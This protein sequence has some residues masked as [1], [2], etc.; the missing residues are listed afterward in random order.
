M[1]TRKTILVVEDEPMSRKMLQ[2]VLGHSYEVLVSSNAAE[3][4]R[5]LTTHPHIKCI[6]SDL[7]M[8]QTDG[9]TLI[10][11]IRARWAWAHIPIIVL[12][13]HQ[14]SQTR[15]ECLE[16]GAD[17][18][19]VKPFNPKELEAK[20]AAVLR[21]QLGMFTPHWTG[22][23][24][25]T[26]ASPSSRLPIP[27]WKR[28]FDILVASV[29]LTL[30]SPLLAVIAVLIKLDSRGT[31]FYTSKRVGAGY[32]VFD[33]YKFRTMCTQADQ[34][35]ANMEDLNMYQSPIAKAHTPTSLCQQCEVHGACQNRLLKENGW[36]CEQEFLQQCHQKAAFKKFQN[37][38]RITKLGRFLR[39][40]SLDE[41]PQLWNIVVG[42][43]S[44]VGNRPLPLYEAEQLTTDEAIA[45]FAAPAGLTGLWQVT[46]RGKGQKD[47][48]AKERIAL[49]IAYGQ[50][51]APQ[52]DLRIIL[53][54]F[55]ALLQSENV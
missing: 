20:I 29:A 34:L 12:S 2:H 31:V 8:P 41:L 42:D 53:K 48:S 36:I 51:L 28:A 15:I 32:R 40:T 52:N 35:L 55:P 54:T 21:R 27:H 18:F 45:R 13:G 6:V 25:S 9:Q 11:Q 47:M 19:M 37:D 50:T 1:N 30:L 5:Y 17:D 14:E 38:P 33:L 24:I 10:R 4:L 3:A 39:N 23:S 26:S 46:K 43:M 16:L 22:G 44:L 49:D 7:N